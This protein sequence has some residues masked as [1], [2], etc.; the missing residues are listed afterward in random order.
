MKHAPGWTVFE[1]LYMS[2]GTIYIVTDEPQDKW[3]E[4][5]LMTSTGL[6]A[7]NSPENIASRE[8]TQWDLDWISVAEAQKRWGSR[9]MPIDETTVSSN[10][11]SSSAA[12]LVC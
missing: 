10:L 3:P 5:R 12:L 8:P 6:E 2:N 11:S 7:V 9:V 1:N 4:R